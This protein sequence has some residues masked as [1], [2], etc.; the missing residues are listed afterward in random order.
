MDVPSCTRIYGQEIDCEY[1]YASPPPPP[2]RGFDGLDDLSPGMMA[3]LL[4]FCLSGAGAAVHLVR[5]SLAPRKSIAEAAAM[6]LEMQAGSR[7]GTSR[8]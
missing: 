8:S 7:W 1:D 2:P 3:L 6:A 4:L 5:R